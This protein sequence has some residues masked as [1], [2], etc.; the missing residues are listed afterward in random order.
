MN[1]KKI[2]IPL[3]GGL[4]KNFKYVTALSLTLDENY[5][6]TAELI[7]Q[8]G[9]L[10]GEP[11]VVDLPLES[12]IIDA[13]YDDVN[14]MLILTLQNGNTIEV[15]I[16]DLISGLV[17]TDQITQELGDSSTDI[18]SQ[19]AT[20]TAL[21]AIQESGAPTTATVAQYV[22]QTYIDTTNGFIY[23][24]TAI[25]TSGSTTTYT[26]VSPSPLTF[27]DVIVEES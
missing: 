2:M 26:W 10:V 12:M 23:M 20:T 19:A 21:T 24:C 18:M 25:T 6:L 16:A 3:G 4:P 15:P 7:D 5:V 11:Q 1:Y 22:G 14:K 8:N 9:D 13:S 17:S 27:T